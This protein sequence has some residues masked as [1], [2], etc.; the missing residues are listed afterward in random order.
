[1]K[2]KYIGGEDAPGSRSTFAFERRW[3]CDEVVDMDRLDDKYVERFGAKIARHPAFET[4]G[5][6]APAAVQSD[7]PASVTEVV[8]DAAP[9]VISEAKGPPK[10]SRKKKVT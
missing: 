6:L 9:S 4:L 1:M 3:N 8:G 5:R 10:A 2:V 7:P